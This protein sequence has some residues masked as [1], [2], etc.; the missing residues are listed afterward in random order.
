MGTDIGFGTRQGVGLRFHGTGQ[1]S[2]RGCGIVDCTHEFAM[3]RPAGRVRQLEQR[4]RAL[5][6]VG[7]TRGMGESFQGLGGRS[8]FEYLIIDSTIMRAHQHA[9]GA[10]G[11]LKIRPSDVARRLDE[12]GSHR[13]R[14]AGNPLRF[15][16]TGGQV[17]DV[18]QAEEL[19]A[20]VAGANLIAD[21]AYDADHLRARLNDAGIVAVIPSNP[22]RAQ[23]IPYDAELYKERH[24][25]ECYINKIKHFRRIATRYAKKPQRPTWPCCFLSVPS[26]G[27]DNCQQDL[28]GLPVSTAAGPSKPLYGRGYRQVSAPPTTPAPDA[29]LRRSGRGSSAWR[30]HRATW[31]QPP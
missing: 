5:F 21:T 8:D 22:S 20:D 6:P 9:S 11:G 2:V 25:V 18:T 23:A 24:L 14:W 26:S 10:K 31:R 15:I 13:C 28:A 16:L 4:V 19:I 7:Q 12:Q 17:G 30:H 1:S 27:S 3:A 29:G